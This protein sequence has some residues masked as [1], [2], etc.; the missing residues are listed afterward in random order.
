[1]HQPAQQTNAVGHPQEQPSKSNKIT[2]ALCVYRFKHP[3][4]KHVVSL[5]ISLRPGRHGAWIPA[6]HGIDSRM[7]K[8]DA[9]Q[10]E[11]K[12]KRKNASTTPED[13]HQTDINQ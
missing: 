9:N 5:Q 2:D 3:S 7:V 12:R 4:I 1:M 10:R 6:D 8:E 11:R 13:H